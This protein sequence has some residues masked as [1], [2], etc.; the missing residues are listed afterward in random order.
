MTR[1]P[2]VR[3]RLN[4]S[5]TPSVTTTTL[6]QARHS[7]HSY[8]QPADPVRSKLPNL[9]VMDQAAA[10][11]GLGLFEARPARRTWQFRIRQQESGTHEQSPGFTR[12]EEASM[13]KPKSV[14]IKL[15]LRIFSIEGIWEPNDV[16]RLA[17]WELYVELITRISVVPLH[18]G[19]AR[20]ALWSLYAIFGQAREIL[21]RHGP[22]V[23]EAKRGGDYNLGYLIVMMLNFT[24]RPLLS[25]WHPELSAWE[26]RRSP[27][28]SIK[29]HE[30]AWPQINNLRSQIVHAGTI[31]SEYAAVLAKACGIP[32]LHLG[33][34]SQLSGI[35]KVDKSQTSASE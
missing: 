34:P 22:E 3:H 7:A 9:A 25:Y 2:N 15:D 31:L 4:P 5:S 28:T 18:D 35:S 32:D 23:A 8:P 19:I 6:V 16:E 21:R 20:E 1:S 14:A 13:R 33:D 27:A 17:A 26:A 30:D 12:A 10:A 11:T 29:D 24:I